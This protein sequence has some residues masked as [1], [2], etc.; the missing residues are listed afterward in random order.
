MQIWLTK[1]AFPFDTHYQWM[2][3]SGDG[4]EQSAQQGSLCAL[5]VPAPLQHN[6]PMQIATGTLAAHLVPTL[7]TLLCIAEVAQD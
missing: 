7:P 6:L 3:H 2:H 1:D 5:V 4:S